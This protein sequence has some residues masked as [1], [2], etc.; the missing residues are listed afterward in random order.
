MYKY[1][2]FQYV[3]VVCHSLYC[4]SEVTYGMDLYCF[5][6]LPYPL[7]VI[8]CFFFLTVAPS[9]APANLTGVF[10]SSTSLN[11]T[12]SLPPVEDR[13]GEILGYSL[14]YFQVT[15]DFSV[16]TPSEEPVIN[17]TMFLISGLEIYTEYNVSVAAFTAVGTGP[18]ASVIA[19]TDS[20]GEF[21]FYYSVHPPA[22]VS[23]VGFVIV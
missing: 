6:P 15:M 3:A 23:D 14:S 7:F 16:G 12:W 11:I 18:F 4:S 5:H 19:R 20:S 17:D 1:K 9:A 22:H 21:D 2:R 13:N 10:A 8:L